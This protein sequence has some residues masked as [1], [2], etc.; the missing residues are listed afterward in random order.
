MSLRTALAI[1]I[2]FAL[3]TVASGCSQS[4]PGDEGDC[5][6][7]LIPGACGLEGECLQCITD[8][9][10]EEHFVCSYWGSC[11][12]YEDWS[13]ESDD[14]CKRLLDSQRAECL[15]EHCVIHCESMSECPYGMLCEHGECTSTRCQQDGTCPQ[16][17]KPKRRSLE[18]LYDPCSA[19]GLVLGGCGLSGACVE[20]LTDAQCDGS[21]CDLGGLCQAPG[22]MSDADCGLE[23]MRCVS[24]LCVLACEDAHD[25]PEDRICDP[26]TGTCQPVRCDDSGE[27]GQWGWYPK[28]GTLACTYDPCRLE[29]GKVPGV[30]GLA[31]TC[32]DCVVDEDCSEGQ[33]CNL[34]GECRDD[35][36]CEQDGDCSRPDELCADGKCRPACESNSDCVDGRGICM[37]AGGCYFERCSVEGTC[38]DG[39]MPGKPGLGLI[40]LKRR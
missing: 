33:V 34:H 12:F 27:C 30:C 7:G 10:C 18:C 24:G 38:P 13:C 31:E 2:A 20:C 6:E 8:D 29:P 35:P 3:A 16:G 15:D 23:S 19:Q 22:C 5:P 32:I 40:C 26:D 4:S 11:S 28:E 36:E 25:C 21:T 14:T 39:W 37:Q 1:W 9:D 17:W